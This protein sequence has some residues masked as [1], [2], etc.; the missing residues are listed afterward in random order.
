M[1]KGWL[2]RTVE[3]IPPRNPGSS[4]R[5]P[6]EAEMGRLQEGRPTTKPG[7]ATLLMEAGMMIPGPRR[8]PLGWTREQET[9]GDGKQGA[10][11][12]ALTPGR[13]PR[14]PTGATLLGRGQ[15]PMGKS[16]PTALRSSPPVTRW[17]SVGGRSPAGG[18]GGARGGKRRCSRTEGK[19]DRQIRNKGGIRVRRWRCPGAKRHRQV[20]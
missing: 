16:P 15:R 17:A 4:P 19:G 2:G 12:P 20:C 6:G 13:R 1:A 5:S 18:L 14:P 11:A 3:M 8:R 10:G 9:E 7:I